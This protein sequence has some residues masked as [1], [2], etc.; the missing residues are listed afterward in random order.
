MI[1]INEPPIIKLRRELKD[2]AERARNTQLAALLRRA[3]REL[4]SREEAQRLMTRIN[5]PFQ[6][7]YMPEPNSGCWLWLRYV[8][9]DGYG[10]YQIRSK[11][12]VA[13][14]ASYELYKGPVPEHLYVLHKCDVRC[15]VNPDHLWLGTLSDNM[16][17]MHRKNRHHNAPRERCMRGHEFTEEN[18]LIAKDGQRRCRICNK[19]YHQERYLKKKQKAALASC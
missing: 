4:A 8:A 7:C 11:Q 12:V 1:S 19:K 13:H 2:A 10:R 9:Q 15:C 18:T 3:H 14:R 6:E 17:D 5:L 16:R